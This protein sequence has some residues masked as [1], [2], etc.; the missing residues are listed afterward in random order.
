MP[1]L[2]YFCE[3]LSNIKQVSVSI[4]LQHDQQLPASVS[5]HPSRRVLTIAFGTDIAHIVLP[6]PI[7]CQTKTLPPSTTYR[8]RACQSFLSSTSFESLASSPPV[9][10]DASNLTDDVSIYCTTCTTRIVPRGKV[11]TWKNLPSEHWADL[12]DLWHCHKPHDEHK[13][14]PDGGKYA[15]V[16]RILAE[17][18]LGLVDQ[19]YVLLARNDCENIDCEKNVG[20]NEAETII[21]QTCKSP[22]GIVDAK[23]DGVR[24]MKWSLALT[25]GTDDEK[26]K[27]ELESYTMQQWLSAQF[28]TLADTTGQRKLLVKPGASLLSQE[29]LD[30]SGLRA[31][32]AEE[33]VHLWVFNPNTLVTRSGKPTATRALKIYYQHLGSKE[34]LD[35]LGDIET[36]YLPVGVYHRFRK[37]LDEVNTRLPEDLRTWAGNWMGGWLERF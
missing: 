29:H 8:L 16:G 10:W 7:A 31:E 17:P 25:F 35:Q 11:Q 4:D 36:V 14:N 12:M 9:P 5:L 26:D 6:V 3:L 2:L 13:T 37:T 20:T 28:I 15:G 22:L 23:S 30:G 18:S 33:G 21:C 19:M 27:D 1:D 32:E 24:L 34:A